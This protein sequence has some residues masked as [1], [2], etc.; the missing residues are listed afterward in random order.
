M[1]GTRSSIS[2]HLSL[3]F[4]TLDSSPSRVLTWGYNSLLVSEM[5]IFKYVTHYSCLF[6]YNFN[7]LKFLAKWASAL[8]DE[9]ISE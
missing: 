6:S 7:S 8:S 2:M 4:S 5:F 3:I 1:A 9:Y